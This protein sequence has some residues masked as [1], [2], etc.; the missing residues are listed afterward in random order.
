VST[1]TPSSYESAGRRNTRVGISR[2]GAV[3]L[4]RAI[5]TLGTGMALH[6]PD[7]VAYKR[8]LVTGGKKPMIAMVA[9]AHRAHRLAFAMMRAQTVYDHEKW[10]TSV[11]KGRPATITPTAAATT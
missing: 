3:E 10:A 6:E 7:F 4:R 8:R 5:I 9:V 11:A 2:E 1:P